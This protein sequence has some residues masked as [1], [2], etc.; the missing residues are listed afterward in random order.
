MVDETGKKKKCYFSLGLGNYCAAI[1]DQN[2]AVA[3]QQQLLKD[4]G[5]LVSLSFRSLWC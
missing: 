2:R 5:V 4:S 3:K 1:R